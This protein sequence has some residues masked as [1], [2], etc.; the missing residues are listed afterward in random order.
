MICKHINA[1]CSASQVSNRYQMNALFDPCQFRRVK[2]DKS[3]VLK[4][5]LE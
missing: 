3:V 4:K 2:Y 5:E 1:K